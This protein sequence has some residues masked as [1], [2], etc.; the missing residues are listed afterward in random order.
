[1]SAI[2]HITVVAPTLER[3]V[4]YVEEALGV[5]MG[6]GG[7]HP[8]MGTHNRLL[9]LGDDLFLEVIAIDP[10]AAQPARTRW[11]ALDALTA[12]ASPRLATWVVRVDD[13]RAA[14][15]ALSED[16]G[17]IETLTRGDLNWLLTVPDDG[18]LPLSGLAPALI[19]WHTP[20]H[21][22][23]RMPPSACSLRRL[24]LFHP[25]PERLGALLGSMGLTDERVHVARIDAGR[26][27]TLI[28]HLDT[29]SGLRV[30]GGDRPA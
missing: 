17:A 28:A 9:R 3:G 13:V 8:R 4:A 6:P 10:A 7:A 12:N 16:V 11:F 1:V 21:P 18:S 2:D 15:A 25:D 26:E 27:P 29:P 20:V 19:E 14:T 24:E 30:L 22:A 5:A 23:S